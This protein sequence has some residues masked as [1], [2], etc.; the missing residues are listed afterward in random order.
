M[1][2]ELLNVEREGLSQYVNMQAVAARHVSETVLHLSCC[3]TS[4]VAQF[5]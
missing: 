5:C 1:Y 4:G 3:V 2:V